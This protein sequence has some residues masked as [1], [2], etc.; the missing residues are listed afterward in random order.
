MDGSFLM[1]NP[2][3]RV[4]KHPRRY[5]FQSPFTLVETSRYSRF[6]DNGSL[7]WLGILR[8]QY[9]RAAFTSSFNGEKYLVGAVP[10]LSM[11]CSNARLLIDKN[12]QKKD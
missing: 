12:K 6:K 4:V 11:D 3:V 7:C 5:D 1:V 9:D 10:P 8:D 2:E